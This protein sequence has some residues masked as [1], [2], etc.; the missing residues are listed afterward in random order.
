M[1]YHNLG[2]QSRVISMKSTQQ[3]RDNYDTI[4]GKQ[5]KEY[6]EQLEPH[7]DIAGNVKEECLAKV[8]QLIT[9]ETVDER[10]NRILSKEEPKPVSTSGNAKKNKKRNNKK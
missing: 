9:N 1:E 10:F 5:L 2:N 4:F 7:L 6:Q 3:Y 8:D